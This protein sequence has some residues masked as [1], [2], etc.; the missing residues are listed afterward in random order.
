MKKGYYIL[1]ALAIIF[2]SL[3][4][5]LLTAQE[6][7]G[8]IYKEALLFT[9]AISI[10]QAEYVEEVPSKDLIYGALRGMLASLDKHS[11]FMNP[12]EYRE[13][14]VE[15]KG[16][17]GGL[18]IV[19]GIKDSLLTIIS[20]L[21]DTPAHRAGVKAGDKIVKIDGESTKDITLMEAVKS[22][23]GKPGTDCALTIMREDEKKLLDFT[24]TRDIIK[25]KSIKEAKIIEDKIGYIR[26]VE[27]QEKTPKE[28]EKALDSLE[29][30]GIDSLI[31]DL[32]NNPGG[33]LDVA[34]EVADKFISEGTIVSTRGR[35]KA[36]GQDFKS[37]ARGTHPEYPMVV[38]INEGS[39]SASEIVA[40]AIHDHDRGVLLGT[41]TFGKGS[42]QTVVPLADESAVRLTTAKYFTP[43]GREIH[44]VGISPDIVVERKTPPSEEEEF[45][46]AEGEVYD[47]QLARAIDLLK[48]IKVWGT[49]ER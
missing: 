24:I 49:F 11:Q 45:I 6:E 16:E 4:S 44:E 40:G 8:S 19:I 43:S 18:G 38:L 39:A 27:F 1:I 3:G 33:L 9:D 46:E 32:R 36:H 15:T 17:F 29:K 26:L 7:E 41:R 21:E 13:M 20:P 35:K 47:E 37:H 12:D 10:I 5:G 34:V 22:M 31:L 48:G 23:R 2:G 25:I 30:E 42:V 14:Q 28:L